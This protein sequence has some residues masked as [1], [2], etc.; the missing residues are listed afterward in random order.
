MCMHERGSIYRY[1][2]LY[3]CIHIYADTQTYTHTHMFDQAAPSSFVQLFLFRFK[4]NTALLD[5]QLV[6]PGNLAWYCPS[7]SVKN[8]VLQQARRSCKLVTFLCC[9]SSCFLALLFA[10]RCSV[11][12]NLAVRQWAGPPPM[13]WQKKQ[14]ESNYDRHS[15]MTS[16]W[17]SLLFRLHDVSS[18]FP[19]VELLA[20]LLRQP[21]SYADGEEDS[22]LHAVHVPG[23][24]VAADGKSRSGC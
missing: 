20:A 21:D 12:R 1:V 6:L 2:S 19:T 14:E 3:V 17:C 7:V 4:P 5:L 23:L 9:L 22:S 8:A 15:R 24:L 11:I 16:L 13:M 10:S 18:R